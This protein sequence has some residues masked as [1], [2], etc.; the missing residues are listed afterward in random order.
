M[1]KLLFPIL[2]TVITLAGVGVMGEL[3]I[4]L[5]ADDGMQF[6]LEMWKYAR[7]VKVVSSDPLIGH[8]HGSNRR[9]R[10]MGVDLVTNSQGLRDREFSLEPPADTLRIVMLGDSL[11]LGWGVALE[12]TFSKRLEALLA[13]NGIKAEVINTGVGNWNTI[14]EVEYFLTKAYRYKPDVVI[15]NYFINDAEPIPQSR[16]P[17][18]IMRHCYVCVFLAGRLDAVLRQFT[19]RQNWKN[20]YLSLYFGE[21]KSGWTDARAAINKLSDYC[22]SNGLS[23]LIA[24]LPELHDVGN[25]QFQAVS[26]LVQETAREDDVPFVDLLPYLRDQRS[27]TLWVTAPDPHPNAL[28]HKL[29]AQ[30]LFEACTVCRRTVQPMARGGARSQEP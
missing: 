6:D 20:Y 22:K 4:R 21:Q 26:D 25:Y 30:G 27:D 29:I 8:E 10:L 11:T 18:F 15:L 23:L 28:A 3:V 13:Q 19:V 1:R 14:Q 24:H 2:L 17:S 5:I 9:A 7:D 16:P 12:S